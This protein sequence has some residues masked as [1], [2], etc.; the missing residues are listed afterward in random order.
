MGS[1]AVVVV[2][3]LLAVVAVVGTWFAVAG[4][5][6]GLETGLSATHA[7]LR[8][9]GDASVWRERGSGEMR[10]EIASFRGALDSL[11]AREEERRTREEESWAVLH[12]V[13]AVLSGGQRAGRAGENVLREA[14]AHLPPSMVVSDFRVN[15]KVVEFGLVL[16]DGRRLPIDSKWPADRE[17]QA[18]AEATDPVEQERLVRAIE[19]GRASCRERVFR[20]V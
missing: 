8:R 1:L 6:R 7:E 4:L 17:L 18:L 10:S 3:V 20:T 19:I 16:P 5:Q 13:A 12:Q 14:L 15:G 9:L 11:R 2:G